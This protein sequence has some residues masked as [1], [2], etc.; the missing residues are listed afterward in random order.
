MLGVTKIAKPNL[1]FRTRFCTVR[2]KSS[3]AVEVE[4]STK[5]PFRHVNVS[6]GLSSNTGLCLYSRPSTQLIHANGYCTSTSGQVTDEHDESSFFE[7]VGLFYDRAV[8]LMEPNLVN[9]MKGRMSTEEKTQRV[10]GIL[11]M[12]KPCNRLISMTFPI[13]LDNGEYQIIQGWRAQHSDHI[14]PVK[15]GMHKS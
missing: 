10:R 8:E 14:S 7:N 5:Q 9:D 15:G 6:R 1:L 3:S 2:P 13:K 4:C 12:I 11:A